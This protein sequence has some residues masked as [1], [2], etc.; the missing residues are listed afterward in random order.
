MILSFHA[1]V[2]GRDSMRGLMGDSVCAKST[3]KRGVRAAQAA[4]LTRGCRTLFGSHVLRGRRERGGTCRCH[5]TGEGGATP[6]PRSRQ[7]ARDTS[8]PGRGAWDRSKRWQCLDF[9]AELVNAYPGNQPEC[10]SALKRR[11][12]PACG[13]QLALEPISSPTLSP[14]ATQRLLSSHPSDMRS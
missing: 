1:F 5:G 8:H 13:A 4:L 11:P 3:R 2:F 14:P 7:A 6:Q 12:Q 10:P 9:K